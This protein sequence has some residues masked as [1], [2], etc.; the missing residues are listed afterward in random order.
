MGE[1]VVWLIILLCIPLS[2]PYVLAFLLFVGM[3][4]LMMVAGAVLFLTLHG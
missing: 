2:R 4:T 1:I 3:G